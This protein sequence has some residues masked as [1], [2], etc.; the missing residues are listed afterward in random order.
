MVTPGIA[1]IFV[2]RKQSWQDRIE[3]V[4]TLVMKKTQMHMSKQYLADHFQQRCWTVTVED[5]DHLLNR[6]FRFHLA[7][8]FSLNRV[9]R[10]TNYREKGVGRNSSKNWRKVVY[11]KSLFWILSRWVV[12]VMVVSSLHGCVLR[13]KF[14]WVEERTTWHTELLDVVQCLPKHG[15]FNKRKSARTHTR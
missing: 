1:V 13:G 3:N 12:G 8:K 9:Q 11:P 14:V 6:C 7:Q 15:L 4:V 10:Q 2:N 5:L